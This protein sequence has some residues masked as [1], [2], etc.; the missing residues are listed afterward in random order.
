MLRAVKATRKFLNGEYISEYVGELIDEDEYKRRNEHYNL[1]PRHYGSFMYEFTHN[2]D[3]TLCVD[4][5]RESDKFGRLVNHSRMKKNGN[6]VKV[7]TRYID[8]F[9]HSTW[10]RNLNGI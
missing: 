5:T 9:P 8:A 3:E 6:N 1:H 10:F 4:A 2:D 7:R